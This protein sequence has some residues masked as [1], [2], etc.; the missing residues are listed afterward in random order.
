MSVVRT[1][2]IASALSLT[3]V[4]PAQ[5]VQYRQLPAEPLIG[6]LGLGGGV[7]IVSPKD[8]GS[9]PYSQSSS[10]LNGNLSVVA[11]GDLLLPALLGFTGSIEIGGMNLAKYDE[12]MTTGPKPTRHIKLEGGGVFFLYDDESATTTDIVLDSS[13]FGNTTTTTYLPGI[14]AVQR[15][16]FGVR[17]GVYIA[18][19]D[20]QQRVDDFTYAMPG[21][22]LLQYAN[23]N[24]KYNGVYAGITYISSLASAI[25][26]TDSSYGGTYE[27]RE[28]SQFYVDLIMGSVTRDM[29]P[30]SSL[31]SAQQAALENGMKTEKT[32]W[33]VGFR[34]E[35]GV[36]A[37]DLQFGKRPGYPNNWY[38]A[39]NLALGVGF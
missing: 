7:D 14:P 26:V 10:T 6:Y 9:A 31:S 27:K 13:T 21:G 30:V 15:S 3:A 23:A 24:L 5:A 4:L 16:L 34:Q 19:D 18:Q 11:M 28:L 8:K 35:G 29:A 39:Y 2:L 36:M 37:Q 25:E 32:G 33:R 12:T 38:L 1:T 20:Y 22:T 17:G